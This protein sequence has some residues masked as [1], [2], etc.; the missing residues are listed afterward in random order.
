[1]NKNYFF[2]AFCFAFIW[3]SGS[4]QAQLQLDV[5]GSIRAVNGNIAIVNGSQ[6]LTLT[7][8]EAERYIH[9]DV[10]GTGHS[11][12][13]IYIGDRGGGNTNKVVML[14][15]VGIG[16]ATPNS[17]LQVAGT[18]NAT[19]FV[20]DG[21][22]LTNLP[23]GG[24]SV[25]S[26]MGNDAYYNDGNVSIGTSDP[27]NGR[28]LSIVGNTPKIL[29]NDDYGNATDDFLIIN[30]GG[31]VKFQNA[32]TATDMMT[33]LLSNGNV[34]IGT[35]SPATKLE[36][37]GN[38]TGNTGGFAGGVLQ[39][40]S[41]SEGGPFISGHN[42]ENDNTQLW[43]LGS[44]NDGTMGIALSNRQN[45]SLTLGTNNTARMTINGVGDVQIGQDVGALIH[46]SDGPDF[47]SSQPYNFNGAG[48]GILFEYKHSSSSET[49]GFYGDGDFA[50]IFSPG[51]QGS[52]NFDP[53]GYLLLLLDE[54]INNY[55]WWVDGDGSPHQSSDLNRKENIEKIEGALEKILTLRGVRYDF[56]QSAEE[57]AK[58]IGERDKSLGVI[59]Q[60]VEAILPELVMDSPHGDKGVHYTGF[61]PIFIEAFKEQQVIINDK[62]T[63]IES[64][65]TQIAQQE[66][67]L[68]K[69][70]NL[71]LS[72]ASGQNNP[73]SSSDKLVHQQQITLTT[74]HL[75]QNQPNPF[76]GQTTI[77]YFLPESTQK[78]Q[79]QINDINGKVLRIE[80]IEN[81]GHGI[82]HLDAKALPQGT[83][84]Y[85]LI[86]DGQLV[87]TK[88]MILMK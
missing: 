84:S 79:I 87:E 25:W 52:L 62:Q 48:D 5:D 83:Y 60:E 64:L 55:E 10:G 37:L 46:Y 12:D 81:V 68:K 7:G 67:R 3:M 45:A 18:V 66:E 69:L 31:D 13:D 56:K 16:T 88:Q 17:K 86:V 19:A 11:G 54:D 43:F 6:G 77:S 27:L 4:L 73:H 8:N 76:N 22:G 85:S 57:K 35:T 72:G 30:G 33:F 70:E 42:S 20:G 44:A 63:Q 59:A 65:Q 28:M 41:L 47:G 15:N 80:N 51:D 58:Q 78:A 29:L 26:T 82:L 50:V 24:S 38:F 36:V 21:S 75:A 40:R 14:G 39:L 2:I 1:M 9:L 23:G 74:P 32:T 53:E 49:S 34:G 71:L 61:V